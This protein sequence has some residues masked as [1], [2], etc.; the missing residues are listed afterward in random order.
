MN[1]SELKATYPW[2]PKSAK[3]WHQHA[4]GGGWVCDTADVA[5]SAYVGSEALVYGEAWVGGGAR[6]CG[7]ARV[8]GEARVGGKARVGGEALVYGEARVGGWARV[9]GKA[10]VGGEA[11][12]YGGRWSVSPLI[13]SG[14]LPWA[15]VAAGPDA[16]A[17]GCEYHSLDEWEIHAE[18]IALRH[19]VSLDGLL[20]MWLPVF[21]QWFADHPIKDHTPG[22]GLG[23]P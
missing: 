13:V 23:F 10:R 11:R 21:R 8:G 17:I 1:W 6:V 4:N 9:C 14:P 7:K 5:P 12:V 3:G 19:H 16:V 2:L 15:I 22:S 18:Q 20:E